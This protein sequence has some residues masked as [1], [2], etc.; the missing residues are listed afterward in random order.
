MSNE[1]FSQGLSSVQEAQEMWLKGNL[2]DFLCD[3]TQKYLS[4]AYFPWSRPE[5]VSAPQV[6]LIGVMIKSLLYWT[7]PCQSM[8]P[9]VSRQHLAAL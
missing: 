8:G 6:P 5:L 4:L 2:L 7:L 9:T 1:Y 3:S